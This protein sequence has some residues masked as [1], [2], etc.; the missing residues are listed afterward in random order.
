MLEFK[1]QYKNKPN[2]SYPNYQTCAVRPTIELSEW[3]ILTSLPTALVIL[4]AQGRIV[5]LNPAAE[6]ML[7]YGLVDTLWVGMSFNKLLFPGR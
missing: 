6:A 2:M 7:G 4:N 1:V 3:D 5:W